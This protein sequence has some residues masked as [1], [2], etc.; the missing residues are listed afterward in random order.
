MSSSAKSCRYVTVHATS[1]QRPTEATRYKLQKEVQRLHVY[2][3]V[4]VELLG[5]FTDES[6]KWQLPDQRL[7]R[8]LELPNLPERL[9]P[10]SEPMRLFDP[11]L[12]CRLSGIF[13]GQRFAGRRPAGC[14]P[15]GRLGPACHG[16]AAR[17][18]NFC[19]VQKLRENAEARS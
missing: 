5:H 3:Q 4:H 19:A 14:F 6:L 12:G 7:H 18:T 9:C 16:Y 11:S 1:R 8:L 17:N 13:G 10:R 15:C 2:L